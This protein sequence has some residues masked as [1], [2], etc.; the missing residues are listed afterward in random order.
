M[1]S[2]GVF[3]AKGGIFNHADEMGW[4]KLEMHK[5][6]TLDQFMATSS[7]FYDFSIC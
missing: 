2:V 1:P 6:H 3:Q 4:N 5:T 7:P